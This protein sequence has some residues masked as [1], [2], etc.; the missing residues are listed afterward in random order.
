M[1]ARGHHQANAHPQRRLEHVKEWR[2]S[3]RCQVFWQVD[4]EIQEQL[5]SAAKGSARHGTSAT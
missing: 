5:E 1:L 2:I 4:L 3:E